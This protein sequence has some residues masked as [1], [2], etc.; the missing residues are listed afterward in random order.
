MITFLSA[1]HPIKYGM[2]AGGLLSAYFLFFTYIPNFVANY[3]RRRLEQIRY[4][5]PIEYNKD[6]NRQREKELREQEEAELA[7][8]RAAIEE[9]GAVTPLKCKSV[10]TEADEDISCPSPMLRHLLTCKKRGAKNCIC[11]YREEY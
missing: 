10:S 6:I 3:A 8:A 11:K 2:F 9:E 5:I 7:S 4:M 1:E